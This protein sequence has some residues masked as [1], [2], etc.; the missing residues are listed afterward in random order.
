MRERSTWNREEV[1]KKAA[2]AKKADPYTMNQD[3][4]QPAADKYVT[5]D[6]STFAEDVHEPNTW[7]SEYANGQT[8]R[9]EIGLPEMR[10][11]TFNHSEKTASEVMIKK[12][13]LCIAVAKLMLSG[14]KVASD[15]TA[16][17][18]QAV[19]L[20][21]LPDRELIATHK[22]LAEEGEKPD[23]LKDK[24]EEKGQD[25]QA[26]QEQQQAQQ[27]EQQAQQQEQQAQ[28]QQEQQAQAQQQQ[29][30]QTQ[31]AAPKTQ[32]AAPQVA[33][34][35][36]AQIQQLLASGN[37]QAAQEQIQQMMQQQNQGQQ[38]QGQQPQQQQMQQ[39]QGQQAQ[40]QQQQDDQTLD[41]MLAA[42]DC[43]P[44]AEADIEMAPG[45]M[46]VGMDDL[47]PEDEVLRNLFA[48]DD[49]ESEG[50][51]DQ[52]QQKQANIRTASTRTVGTRPSAG[53]SKIGGASSPTSGVDLSRLWQS[54]PDMRE[55]FGLK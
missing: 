4:P 49:E 55:V 52:Q 34:T 43:A 44:M 19:A 48:N 26:Q 30:Q 23:F 27:Q 3:H 54:A 10:S 41:Q 33:G 11:D 13:D 5:G 15:V 25:K 46:D 42:D 1:V 39:D 50:Q 16:V 36:V 53:V 14:K 22:R 51:Q 45:Q 18:D 24:E 40:G 28:Q 21:S 9:D 47:G 7:E 8:K 6:P 29:D 12:A 17:E 38:A 32:V 37:L 31:V 20:M 35:Q 2:I